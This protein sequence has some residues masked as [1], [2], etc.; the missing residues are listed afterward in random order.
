M[1]F[2]MPSISFAR[3]YRDSILMNRVWAY[4]QKVAKNM[5]KLD[6]NAYLIYTIDLKKR[7]F[8]LW[9]IPNMYSVAKGDRRFIFEEYGRL[10]HSSKYDFHFD[11]QL[12][13]S[14][15]PRNRKPIPALFEMQSPNYHGEQIYRDR[16]LSPFWKSN[17]RYYK[18]KILY[19]KDNVAMV[20]FSP[21]VR[22]TQ[23]VKGTAM[24]NFL[25]GAIISISFEAEFD[26]LRFSVTTEMN[27]END[28][29]MPSTNN[30]MAS[31]NFLGNK[32]LGTISSNYGLD[33]TLPDSLRNRN[34]YNTIAS[35][36][37][38]PLT[39]YQDSIYLHHYERIKAREGKREAQRITQPVDSDSISIFSKNF[40]KVK[41]FLWDDVGDYMVN[42]NDY[43]SKR[44]Y[45]RLS[46]LFNPLYMSYSTSKGVSYKLSAL[47]SFYWN[48]YRYLTFEPRFG[49]S[50]KV[51]QFYYTIPLTFT[52]NAKRDGHVSFV[53]E[54]GNRT[55][56][57]SLAETF[58][59][60]RQDKSIPFPEFRDERF[61]FYNHIGIFKWIGLTTG[62]SYH[63]RKATT[64]RQL[65]KELG[66]VYAY[67]S[68]APYV[69]VSLSPWQSRGPVLTANYERSIKDVLYSN[70]RYERWEF[71]AAYKHNVKRMQI[72]NLRA[73][74]GFYTHRSTDYF[75]DFTNFCDNNL[76]TGWNDD[77]TGQFH[78]IDSRWYNE[79]NYYIRG[80]ISYDSPL[81]VLSW[82]PL[83]G[84][85]LETERLYLSMLNIEHTRFY[86]E[87]GY[88]LKCRYFS[89]AVFA[90]FLNT[91]YNSIGVKFDIELFRR[92]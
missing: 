79:S 57:A 50:S 49:Y 12:V 30:T 56:S 3:D 71:D 7:N 86:C 10:T 9:L 89:A 27:K 66:L 80:H 20:I 2:F 31:F 45:L 15:I 67:R 21:R 75:V 90:S 39:T 87:L 44:S 70:L 33:Y 23:L 32:I 58:N 6:E 24:V 91:N 25:T 4:N 76:P 35:V 63:L 26:M 48:D 55:S 73:G 18:Y 41:D 74:A 68:F 88:G 29:G 22:N 83:V 82:L 81:L 84:Q 34:D 54:N 11:R 17:R 52:Y 72:L 8:L 78:L 61:R 60:K 42:S 85:Y 19:L 51:K 40:N 16:L 65:L 5:T 14:T 53:W 92:W 64:A 38:Q 36:R 47:F 62:V 1:F 46:P 28:T 77:W 43:K 37:P 69:A 59:K 13:F